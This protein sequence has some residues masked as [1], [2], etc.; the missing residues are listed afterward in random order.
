MTMYKTK[1]F[2]CT[3]MK[4]VQGLLVVRSVRVAKQA[5][6]IIETTYDHKLRSVRAMRQRGDRSEELACRVA[7]YVDHAVI[8]QELHKQVTKRMGRYV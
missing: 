7:S 1:G 4:K 5:T 8:V 2:D 3:T 6:E